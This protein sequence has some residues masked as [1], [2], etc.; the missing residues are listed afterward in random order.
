M[1]A[2]G[3]QSEIMVRLCQAILRNG[4][5]PAIIG[6]LLAPGNE[7]IFDGMVDAIVKIARPIIEKYKVPSGW[8]RSTV[9]FYT[10]KNPNMSLEV[11]MR[12]CD[13]SR[14]LNYFEGDMD[15]DL[16][17]KFNDPWCVDKAEQTIF[18]I[19]R[20]WEGWSMDKVLSVA[21]ELGLKVPSALDLVHFAVYI[22][23]QVRHN[24][25]LIPDG[26]VLRQ[27]LAVPRLVPMSENFNVIPTFKVS[28]R[29]VE[30]GYVPCSDR[31]QL[32]SDPA[33]THKFGTF[34]PFLFV[35]KAPVKPTVP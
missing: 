4:A 14:Q 24:N 16:L 23:K 31:F 21:D 22:S 32:A 26:Y 29:C 30:L 1:A 15:A 12:L 13:I 9:A 6:S 19:V 28:D 10:N 34:L 3:H 5:P 20:F 17:Q 8:S 33:L 25:N 11:Y 27:V 7:R 18:S 2:A 35:D